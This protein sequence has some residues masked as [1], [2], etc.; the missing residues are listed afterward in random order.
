MAKPVSIGKIRAE[1]LNILDARTCRQI[2]REL[3]SK[4]YETRNQQIKDLHETVITVAEQKWSLR[5]FA[6]IFDISHQYL[7]DMIDGKTGKNGDPF[8]HV[9]FHE[10]VQHQFPEIELT[11]GYTASFLSRREHQLTTKFASPMENKRFDAPL[12]S[13]SEYII[14]PDEEQY[15]DSHRKAVICPIYVKDSECKYKVDR[16]DKNTTVLA[17]ICLDSSNVCIAIVVRG[18]TLVDDI[19]TKSLREGVDCIVLP[20]DKGYVCSNHFIIWIMRCPIPFFVKWRKENKL[21]PTEWGGLQLDGHRA[22]LTEEIKQA[23]TKAHIRIIQLPAHTSHCFQPLDLST[24]HSMK[25]KVRKQITGFAPKTQADKIQKSVMALQ[26]AT[27]PFANMH[28]FANAA[29]CQDCT[30]IP[31]RSIKAEQQLGNQI[32]KLLGDR[33]K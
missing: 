14:R 29:I 21:L 33:M 6:V 4:N 7:G 2:L 27:T 31:H 22:H 16:S 3:S 9:T 12:E 1:L 28:A 30:K 32:S 23:L 15:L 5:R 18:K 26:L 20:N 17:G 8:T 10:D 25:S 19:F 13:A 11:D 24:F